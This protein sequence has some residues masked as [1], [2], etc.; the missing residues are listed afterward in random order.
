MPM[1]AQIGGGS[2]APT[3]SPPT[4]RPLYAR[5]KVPARTVQEAGWASGS[6]WTSRKISPPPAVDPRTVQPVASR[7][8]NSYAPRSREYEVSPIFYGI[9][10]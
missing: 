4:T 8:T 5:E 3:Y 7:Y 1:Q 10:C 9:H 6:V 2:L